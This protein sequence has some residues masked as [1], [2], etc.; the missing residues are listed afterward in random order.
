MDKNMAED[1]VEENR[2]NTKKKE[3]GGL[4]TMPFILAN[5]ICD[6]FASSG[7]HANM[8]TYLTEVLNMPLVPASN[9]LTNFSGT[10]SFT[11]LIGALIADSFAGRFW[12]IIVGSIIYELGLVSITISAV[13]P[14]LRPPP[15]PTKENCKEASTLQLCILYISLLLTSL[16]TG[17]IRPCVVTFAA[18]QFDMSKS[19]VAS[20]SWNFFNWYYFSMGLATLSALTI[21]V[22]IQDNVGWGWGLGLPTIA[23]AL[24]IIAFLVGSPLYKKLKPGGSPLVRLAQVIVAATK[25]RK[26][27][28]PADPSLLYENKELDATISVNGRLLHTN[29]FKWFDKAAIVTDAEATSLNPPNLW[30]LATVHRVEELKSIVRML[31]IWAAG[32]LHVTSSSHQ[33]SFTIQQARTMDRHLSPSFQIPPASLSIFSVL[34]VLIGI[35][36]YERFFVPLARRFTRNPSGITSLQRMGIGFMVNILATIVASFVEIK[37]KAIA[38]NHNLLD[39]PRAI[40]P[41]SVFWLVPQFALHGVAEVF[42][43][44]GHLEFLYDQSPE[45]MRSTA[46]ALYWIAIAIGNYL[47]TLLVTLVHKYTGHSRN[48]LPDRNLN[49]GR[50][51]YYYWLVSGIQ[52]VNLIYYVTCAWL[53]TH[54]PVEEVG[55]SMDKNDVDLARGRN[56]GNVDGDVELAKTGTVKAQ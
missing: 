7:F 38:A 30:R 4:R 52:V 19:K 49:R 21:V 27:V 13:L 41:I 5:E 6:R 44:V 18:D 12:T 42:M 35:V 26:A 34:T 8:I 36:L 33:H 32:I 56:D 39:K 48:W 9:T 47:G 23:M 53:Y 43:S 16:G 24:S 45:S 25:K 51:E 28:A 10:A 50:L 46:A 40:I 3:L 15:C 22:Y 37:R 11:P 1:G 29:Q 54:K 2:E 20:R 17:G 31:P 55:D 14:S